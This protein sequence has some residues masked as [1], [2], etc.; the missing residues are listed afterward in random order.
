MLYNTKDFSLLY[1]CCG[2]TTRYKDLLGTLISDI[3]LQI[4]SFAAQSERDMMLQHQ[5]E[6]ITAAKK[7]GVTWGHPKELNYPISPN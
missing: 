1:Y 4:M 3:I 5:A 7:R 2:D 6:G